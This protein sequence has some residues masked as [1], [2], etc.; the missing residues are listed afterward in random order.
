ML[1]TAKYIR[2][3]VLIADGVN[4]TLEYCK[5]ATGVDL[6]V[7]N[8]YKLS[9]PGV[10]YK[11]K[12]V[13]SDYKLIDKIDVVDNKL[14]RPFKGWYL[15]VGTYICELNEGCKFGPN[16]VGYIVLRSSLNRNCV[17]LIS[18]VWD[19]NF[20]TEKDGVVNTMSVRINVDTPMGIYIEENARVGQLVVF[21][22]EDGA[23]QYVGQWQGGAIKSNLEESNK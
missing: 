19:P 14:A 2:E 20:T 5:D 8:F 13:V 9:M 3:N 22:T 10:V 17:S 15:P 23:T 4:T 1:R 7:K 21:D 16:D 6:S 18:A 11:D 12:T